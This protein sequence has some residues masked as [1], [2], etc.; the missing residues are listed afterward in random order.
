MYY[1]DTQLIIFRGGKA[2]LF[3]PVSRFFLDPGDTLEHFGMKDECC[4]I[5]V[6]RDFCF[7]CFYL[8][9]LMYSL[10]KSFKFL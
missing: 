2:K 4:A 10:V 1:Y 5:V 7:R 9:V 8:I 3:V 6:E